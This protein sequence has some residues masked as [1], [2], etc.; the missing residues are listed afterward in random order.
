VKAY[1][2]IVALGMLSAIVGGAIVNR[3]ALLS[4]RPLDVAIGLLPASVALL[5][6]VGLWRLRRWGLF[7]L[8]GWSAVML[9]SLIALAGVGLMDTSMLGY[10]VF[11][12][13]LIAIPLMLGV[14]YWRQLQ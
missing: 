13:C 4:S 6:A 7:V 1:A 10:A 8:V 12:I 3:E 11:A 14:R 2:A 5:G 9:A